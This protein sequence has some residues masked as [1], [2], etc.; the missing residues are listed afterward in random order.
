M[1]GVQMAKLGKCLAF[2]FKYPSEMNHLYWQARKSGQKAEIDGAPEDARILSM[3]KA[4]G[5]G[6]RKNKLVNLIL[7]FW[8][9]SVT[10]EGCKMQ[11]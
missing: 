9:V 6:L 7:T 11:L 1:R 3:I 4:V 10:P 2:Y 5:K 8:R